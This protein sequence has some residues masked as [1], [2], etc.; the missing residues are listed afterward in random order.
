MGVLLLLNGLHHAYLNN[1]STHQTCE[2]CI[3]TPSRLRVTAAST[4]C[5][6][7]ACDKVINRSPHHSV[8]S[9]HV[10]CVVSIDGRQLCSS[11]QSPCNVARDEAQTV[12]G[13]LGDEQGACTLRC[14]AELQ[15]LHTPDGEFCLYLHCGMHTL[16]VRGLHRLS[17]AWRGCHYLQKTT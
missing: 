5:A 16:R 9:E 14:Q 10:D 1:S 7:R 12:S 6:R 11:S 13:V 2:C 3:L 17:V 8:P 15:L 4:A